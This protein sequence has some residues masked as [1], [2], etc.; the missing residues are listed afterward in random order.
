ME[1]FVLRYYILVYSVLV[2]LTIILYFWFNAESEAEKE[3]KTWYVTYML[4]GMVQALSSYLLEKK[5]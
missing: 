4:T 1:I 5:V 3:Y 2:G